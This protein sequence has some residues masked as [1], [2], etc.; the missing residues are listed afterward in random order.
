MK[1]SL[2]DL[3]IYL[4]IFIFV[5][6]LPVDLLRLPVEVELTILISLRVTLL[7]FYIYVIL[8]NKIKIFGNNSIKELL[9]FLPFFLI[10]FSNVFASLIYGGF[11]GPSSNGLVLFL[12]ILLCLFGAILEEILFRLFIQNALV[13]YR[14]IGRIILSA[15]IFALC[16]L[17]NAA[18]ARSVDAFVN[19]LLQTVYTFGFGLI[20]AFIYEYSHSLIFVTILHFVFNL[21]NDVLYQ[22]FGGY[23]STLVFILGGLVSFILVFG[24][25][26]FLYKYKFQNRNVKNEVN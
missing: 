10:C 2:T 5:V 6:C 11:V 24:Y 3:L 7:A 12:K 25:G 15:L 19:V 13:K 20:I 4:L 8:K 26:L 14:P 9:I 18:N 17:I 22:F 1:L 21:F 23:T 16:H